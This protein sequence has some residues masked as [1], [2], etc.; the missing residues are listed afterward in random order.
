[1]L[2][3]KVCVFLFYLAAWARQNVDVWVSPPGVLGFM[4]RI[5]PFARKS[6]F[7]NLQLSVSSPTCSNHAHSTQLHNEGSLTKDM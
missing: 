1:M 6:Y 5:P 3:I 7:A 2:E 4:G